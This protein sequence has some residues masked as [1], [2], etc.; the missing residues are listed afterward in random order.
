[1]AL[2]AVAAALLLPSSAW[3]GESTGTSEQ[4]GQAAPAATS[5][6]SE[7]ATPALGGEAPPAPPDNSK[8]SLVL[9]GG[10]SAARSVSLSASPSGGLK[11]TAVLA[12][13]SKVPVDSLRVSYVPSGGTEGEAAGSVALAGGADDSFTAGGERS[14]PLVF[15]L[16]AGSGPE[17]L[18]GTVVIR[19]IRGGKAV[20][21]R[22]ELAVSGV[23][24]D[25]AGISI[26]PEKLSIDAV[27][28]VPTSGP[29]DEAARIQ[30]S[31]PG[32][33]ALLASGTTPAFDLLLRSDHG[34]EVHARLANLEP[35]SSA[36]VATAEVKLEGTLKPGK[37]EGSAP[38]SPLSPTSPKLAIEVESGNSFLWALLAVFI[39]A[40]LGGALYLA[41]GIHR[42]KALLRDEVKSLLRSYTDALGRVTASGE[43]GRPALWTLD[44]YLGK[45]RKAWYEVKWN[46][47]LD[48]DGAVRTIWSDIHWARNEEDLDEVAAQVSELRSRIVRWVTVADS[49]AA[50]QA[51]SKLSPKGIAGHL[52]ED[53]KTAKDSELLLEQIREI[54]P[55]DDGAGK[56][57]IERINRQARWHVELAEA[58]HA[59]AVLTLDVT[60]DPGRYDD[61]IKDTMKQLNLEALDEKASPEAERD[62]EEQVPLTIELDRLK[63][64]IFAVY[65]GDADDLKLEQPLPPRSVFAAPTLGVAA[66]AGSSGPIEEAIVED[67]VMVEASRAE[68]P[69]MDAVLRGASASGSTHDGKRIG[70]QVQAIAQRDLLWTFATALAASAAYIPTI[71][72]ST[73]GTPSDYVGAFAAGF[74]G[75]TVI[76]WAA[77]PLFRSLKPERSGSKGESTTSDDAAAADG[78][79]KAAPTT[80]GAAAQVVPPA[81]QV[82]V[83]IPAPGAQPPAGTQPP[84]AGAAPTAPPSDG[85]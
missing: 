27:G 22:L 25:L 41:S 63:K 60:E 39:G 56:A 16:P 52:W 40:V 50:L 72:N 36:A 21:H 5:A 85:G 3:A 84:P 69:P 29:T 67:R 2:L 45:D 73:W 71:Y 15:T 68:P 13:R 65:K 46:A 19:S 38:L 66:A 61:S 37:Y 59:R 78:S 35:G 57:L 30:L 74:L 82:T 33:P 79:G 12:L 80:D 34:D 8:S 77:L 24:A 42:R 6:T 49:I 83:T 55:G 43:N 48:F 81:P 28:E 62:A 4:A 7:E 14:V 54:E 64:R 10:Q 58:W 20:G 11:G 53:T 75:K 9:L 17:D 51:A 1:M 18:G 26:Q 23:G 70:F 76:N 47:V 44:A 31:G 32:V